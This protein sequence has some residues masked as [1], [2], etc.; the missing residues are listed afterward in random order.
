MITVPL[1]LKSALFSRT[2]YALIILTSFI[3]I[4]VSI[5]SGY[6]ELS[7]YSSPGKIHADIFKIN[8][9]SKKYKWNL[10]STAA[11]NPAMTTL[12][13][14]E[15]D[16]LSGIQLRGII[17]STNKLRSRTILLEGGEQAVY[18]IGD[19]LNSSKTTRVSDITTN[20][21]FFSTEGHTRHLNLLE[22]LTAPSAS[23]DMAASQPQ[24]VL[25][26][27][28]AA[29]PVFTKTALQGLRLLPRNHAT[30]LSHAGLEPGDIAIMLNNLSLK[31]PDNIKKAQASLE[32]LQRVQF[33]LLRN[34]S[35]QRIT[36]SVQQFREGNKTR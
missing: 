18:A 5:N 24:P 29:S 23:V 10:S 22:E 32:T 19:L 9:T 30:L 27:F 14:T 17:Y 26:D 2:L 12:T 31:Q 13:T 35:P 4:F 15:T 21:V 7:K 8:N 1:T 20:Q 11:E 6:I 16:T 33:T 36:V 3:S 28:I 34:A 25:S